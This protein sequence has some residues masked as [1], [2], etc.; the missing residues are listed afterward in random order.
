MWT[1]AVIKSS[2]RKAA[3]GKAIIYGS[4]KLQFLSFCWPGKASPCLHWQG[5][6]CHL[7]E[8][9]SWWTGDGE[10][11]ASQRFCCQPV[12]TLLDTIGHLALLFNSLRPE[13][14]LSM[15]ISEFLN[16]KKLQSSYFF[17]PHLLHGLLFL[18]SISTLIFI[19]L[20]SALGQSGGGHVLVDLQFAG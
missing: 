16:V 13:T 19:S 12:M 7:P 17:A 6:L 1:P 20:H 11:V 4:K 8:T 2:P 15:I 18:I 9:V 14:F 10:P 3:L 5:A